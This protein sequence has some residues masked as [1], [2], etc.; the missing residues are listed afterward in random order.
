MPLQDIY[1]SIKPKMVE[2]IN[3]FTESLKTVHSG[4]ASTLLVEDLSVDSYGT[5]MPLKQVANIATPDANL[6]TITPWDKSLVSA[7]ETAIR[8]SGRN[9]NPTSDGTVVRVAL[10]PMSQE[11]RE[12]LAKLIN[13]MA[14]EARVNLRNIRKEAWETVQNETKVGKLTE[15]DKYMGEK[16]LNKMIDDFNAQIAD[17]TAAKEKELKTI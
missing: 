3:R 13:A 6:I 8:N 4:R 1:A 17:L 16:D 12:E 2:V 15:D 10:P 9:L 7:V 11:R 5:S 14:E